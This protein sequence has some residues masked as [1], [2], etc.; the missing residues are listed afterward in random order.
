MKLIKNVFLRFKEG[1]SDKAYKVELIEV[2]DN[3]YLVNFSFGKYDSVLKECTK[4]ETPLTLS[5]AE[6]IFNELVISKTKKGYKNISLE[7]E[8]IDNNLNEF[9]HSIENQKKEILNKLN[10]NKEEKTFSFI[11]TIIS[12]I[13]NKNISNNRI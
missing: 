7:N 10:Y 5:E 8:M 13:N 9:N 11:K 1:N 2:S 6:K 3:K 12:S 4:T